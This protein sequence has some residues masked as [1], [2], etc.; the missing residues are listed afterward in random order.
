MVE[1]LC[2]EGRNAEGKLF[3]GDYLVSER[4]DGVGSR[5]VQLRGLQFHTHP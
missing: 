4:G 5:S 2:V 1:D 3:H